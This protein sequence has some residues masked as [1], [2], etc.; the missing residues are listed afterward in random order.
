MRVFTKQHLGGNIS[1]L[2]EVSDSIASFLAARATQPEKAVIP[3]SSSTKYYLN[4]S[5]STKTLFQLH[6][7]PLMT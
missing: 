1:C 6:Y 5:L 7:D 3:Y 4:A 2:R